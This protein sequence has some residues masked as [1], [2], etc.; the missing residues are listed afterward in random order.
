MECTKYNNS[1]FSM[2]T[3]MVS[4]D[5]IVASGDNDDKRIL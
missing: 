3:A 2:L 5:N 1:D 4:V